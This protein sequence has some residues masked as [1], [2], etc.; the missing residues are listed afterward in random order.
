MLVASVG[1]NQTHAFSWKVLAM[2]KCH[3]TVIQ[4]FPDNIDRD[5]FGAWISGFS[6]GEAYFGIGLANHHKTPW[7]RFVIQLRVDDRPI[8]ELIR[9]YFGVGIL[10]NY[11]PH[12]TILK[13]NPG[14]KYRINRIPHLS[15]VII[16]HFDRFPVFA[17]K[18]RDF[19]I[20]KA[21]IQFIVSVCDSGQR[22]KGCRPDRKAWW[23]ASELSKLK[24]Y[25]EALKE[26]RRFV[27]NSPVNGHPVPIIEPYRPPVAQ[28]LLFD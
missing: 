10:E 18:Q 20:W 2:A 27:P 15:T 14:V 25:V 7:A 6:A 19:E 12:K 8:L 13:S 3:S 4:P 22:G 23:K 1:S 24:E 9:S 28:G 26:V 11:E 16:P 21:G 5:Q 17:K